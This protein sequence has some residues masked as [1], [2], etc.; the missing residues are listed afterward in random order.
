MDCFKKQSINSGIVVQSIIVIADSA[1]KAEGG[2]LGAA[3]CFN[4]C[5][6]LCAGLARCHLAVAETVESPPPKT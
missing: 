2:Y 6:H 5:A 4:Q 3:F 1:V